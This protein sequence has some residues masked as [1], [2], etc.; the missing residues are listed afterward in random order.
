MFS[1]IL[2]LGPYL[3]QTGTESQI[4][5][6][7]YSEGGALYAL[8]MINAYGGSQTMDYLQE[9]LRNSQNEI[10][11]HGRLFSDSAVAGEATGYA[12]GLIVLGSAGQAHAEEMITYARETQHAKIIRGVAMGLSFVFYG[13]YP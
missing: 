10:V 13:L 1:A 3:P 11:Q 5:G 12:M 6:A 2:S 9:A 8:G 4:Q 7:M